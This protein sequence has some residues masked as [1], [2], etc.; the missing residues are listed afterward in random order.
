MR[1]LTVPFGVASRLDRG[2]SRSL[3]FSPLSLFIHS[4][5]VLRFRTNVEVMDLVTVDPSRYIR[6]RRYLIRSVGRESVSSESPLFRPLDI[7]L[8]PRSVEIRVMD[9]RQS[10]CVNRHGRTQLVNVGWDSWWWDDLCR[11]RRGICVL[12]ADILHRP[13]SSIDGDWD[14]HRGIAKGSSRRITRT[15][16]FC[17]L[18][19]W[20]TVSAPLCFRHNRHFLN[21]L[22]VRSSAAKITEVS[23]A[24]IVADNGGNFVE[25]YLAFKHKEESLVTMEVVSHKL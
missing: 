9:E 11:S 14:N 2:R 4:R 21:F 16:G 3:R 15:R 22:L 18:S 7:Y 12:I 19:T 13:G 24:K 17:C 1:R 23:R 6:D 8:R 20:V 25:F 5:R 10:R